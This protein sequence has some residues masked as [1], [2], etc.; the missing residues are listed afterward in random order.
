V[1][2]PQANGVAGYKLV[3]LQTASQCGL[4]IPETLVTNDPVMARDFFDGCG[5]EVIYKTLRQHTLAEGA[6]IYTSEVLPEHLERDMR[7]GIRDTA[8]LFQK[9]VPKELELRSMV[10]GKRILTA[11][12]YSQHSES[13]RIDFRRGYDDLRYGI[14]DDLPLNL[15]VKLLRFM[16]RMDLAFGMIDFILTPGGEY[17]FLEV[18]PSGQWYWLEKETGLP[19]CDAL[20][21]YLVEGEEP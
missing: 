12:I 7:A 18:N 11:E 2:H 8:H 1:N 10:I 3:Q 16:D 5:G 21:D 6:T 14:H 20:A 9:K 17:V 4:A 15:Q 13:S 19:M